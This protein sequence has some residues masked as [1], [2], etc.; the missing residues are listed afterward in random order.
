MT[1]QDIELLALEIFPDKQ[2]FL[3]I[4]N[5]D[6]ERKAFVQ[7]YLK[8]MENLPKWKRAQEDFYKGQHLRLTKH[9]NRPQ[10]WIEGKIS[11]GSLYLDIQDCTKL[12]EEK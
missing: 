5:H 12:L 10:A 3:G 1:N 8:A 9:N 11:K 6:K 4:N 2:T 7:G